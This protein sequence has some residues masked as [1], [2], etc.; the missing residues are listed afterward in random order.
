MAF[1]LN[2]KPEEIRWPV[3]VRK[4]SEKK[5]GKFD[6]DTFYATF[7]V[8]GSKQFQELQQDESLSE[9]QKVRKFMKGWELKDDSGAEARFDD[10]EVL[11]FVLNIPYLN[12]AI[13]QS[14]LLC[15]SG[16]ANAKN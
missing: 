5:P 6:E 3:K 7:I 10:D 2:R 11:E 9:I 16:G 13:L 1:T 14:Y 8:M 12:V 15:I 4:P